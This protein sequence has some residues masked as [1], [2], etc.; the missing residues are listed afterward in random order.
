MS[1]VLG[2]TQA[3]EAG[4]GSNSEIMNQRENSQSKS[5]AYP[6]CSIAINSQT[7]R[8]RIAVAY[9]ETQK[10]LPRFSPNTTQNTLNV[11]DAD[12][13]AAFLSPAA[14]LNSL[15]SLSPIPSPTSSAVPSKKRSAREDTDCVICL[16][17]M[18]NPHL[19][20]CGH[21]FC[22]EC[23]SKHLE[24]KQSCPLCSKQ[25]TNDH[26]FPNIQLNNLVKKIHS[27]IK[28]QKHSPIMKELCSSLGDRRP[29][30]KSLDSLLAVL[31]QK[32]AVTEIQD[33]VSQAY[34]L[35]HFLEFAKTNKLK[36]FA[37]LQAQINELQRDITT[38]DSM[39]PDRLCDERRAP[40][41][42]SASYL[43]SYEPPRFYQDAS[44][45]PSCALSKSSPLSDAVA[46][47]RERLEPHFEELVQTYTS[48]RTSDCDQ[49]IAGIST[50][51]DDLTRFSQ[52]KS[53]SSIRN[54]ESAGTS[55]IVSSIEFDRDEQ[56]FAA[57]GTNKKIKIYDVEEILKDPLS[58]HLPVKE[59]SWRYKIRYQ[60]A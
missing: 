9:A 49:N 12:A 22:L 48:S 1:D 21:T 46:K 42:H 41:L 19:T 57:A 39:R 52:L 35:L 40:D 53:V 11:D 32:K 28:V 43:R 18:I 5:D 60:Q 44:Q 54:T 24:S 59:I 50:I 45:T 30:G 34:F 8:T 20:P 15:P 58:A 37:E 4:L 55:C 36:E 33:S 51:V 3:D 7:P 2:D 23:I 25:L 10:I 6:R 13:S 17:L 27:S 26:L 56:F 47:R 38:L 31:A 29:S 16:S 14:T